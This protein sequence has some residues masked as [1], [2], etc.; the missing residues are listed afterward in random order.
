MDIRIMEYFLAITREGNISAAAEALHV[1]Q[2]ALSRQI[3]DLEEELGVTLFER[4]SRKI[5]LTE[6]GMILRRRAEE[7]VRLMQ[8][9]EGEIRQSHNA[10][11]G[12]IHI[13]AGESLSFHHLSEIA[14][15]IHKSYPDIRFYIT[16]G[17]TAD[18]I[19]QLNTGL[20][21]VALIFTDY[22]HSLYQGIRLPNE[23]KLGLL[24]RKDD[25]LA[26]KSEITVSDLSGLPL[27]IPRASEALITSDPAFSDLNIVAVYNLIYNASLFVEDGVGYALGFEGLVNTTGDSLLTFIPLVSRISQPGAVIWKKYEVFSP[28][29]NLFLEQLK[30]IGKSD[31]E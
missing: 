22:D 30:A 15:K 20:I 19:E 1:S 2:P 13:G 24:M 4:G 17:D 31:G 10:I 16:S 14:G 23:D 29:V 18:L 8:I 26:C 12:E 5:R 6:E 9:T 25:P 28:A 7:M 27:I 11:S 21:D 3:K